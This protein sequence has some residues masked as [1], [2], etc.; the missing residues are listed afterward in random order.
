[1]IN[2]IY[3]ENEEDDGYHHPQNSMS[4]MMDSYDHGNITEDN[5]NRSYQEVDM[6]RRGKMLPKRNLNRNH[7]QLFF[8]RDQSTDSFFDGVGEIPYSRPNFMEPSYMT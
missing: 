4:M 3:D 2:R 7:H 1:M 5:V 8:A 6:V